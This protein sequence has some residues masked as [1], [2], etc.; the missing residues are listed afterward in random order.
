MKRLCCILFLLSAGCTS[1][2]RSNPYEGALCRLDI[3]TVYPDDYA[4]FRREGVAVRIEDV[5]RGYTYRT[6]TDVSGCAQIRLPNG[7]YRIS[8]SD[9]TDGHIF[10]GTVDNVQL[11]G[12]DLGMNV[13]LVHSKA[14]S[15]LIKEIYCGGC[16]KTP[17]EGKYQSDK[18]II[19]HNNDSEVQYLDSLCF[20]TLD[21]YNSQGTNVWITTDPDTGASLLPDFVPIVQVIWQIGG[22]GTSFPL[23]PGE[24][25]V[26]V[27]CGA[28]DHAAQ[29]PLSVNLNKPGYFVC[30]NNTYF[31]NTLYH[32]APGDQ[33]TP[34]HYLDVVIKLGQ[35]NAFTFSI[36]SPAPVLFRTP[37]TTIQEFVQAAG[38]V[39]QKP[40]STVDRIVKIP[41]DWVVD[42][43]EVFY[44]GSSNN[45]KRLRAEIDAGS[46]T[47]S[48][49]YDGRSLHRHTDEEASAEAGYEVLVDTNNSTTDFYERSQQSLHE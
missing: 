19:V 13:D 37:G 26:I 10:N 14:G 35:A 20:G 6:Q 1:V 7:I 22:N 23:A 21:P 8:V 48:A 15:I 44:G 27:C 41:V 4:G 32:P 45:K 40:G 38:N 39:I 34:D 5:D 17:V 3:E 47:Q 46:V 42:G 9:R 49:L 24:D 28:I 16:M 29:Y 12:R 11:V 43:V 33:I 18:Y 30:Y 36:Y 31:P 25:A 2:D